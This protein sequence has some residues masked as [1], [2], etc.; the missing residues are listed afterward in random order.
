MRD[1]FKNYR[2]RLKNHDH[3]HLS[4]L[5]NLQLVALSLYHGPPHWAGTLWGHISCCRY[6]GY[7]WNAGLFYTVKNSSRFWCNFRV[8]FPLF[9]AFIEDIFYLSLVVFCCQTHTGGHV[10][11]C[12]K[13]HYAR[14]NSD[15]FMVPMQWL[16]LEFYCNFRVFTE[17][18]V[19]EQTITVV[20]DCW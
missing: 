10:F 1:S 4:D 7:L 6:S 9:Q 20:N 16:R 14:K 18:N 8:C 12:V 19:N 13:F 11:L 2:I 17:V 3:L 5:R 15:D